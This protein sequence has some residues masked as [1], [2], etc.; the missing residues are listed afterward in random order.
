MIIWPALLKF[1]GDDELLFV[2]NQQAWDS[3]ASVYAASSQPED[4]L[5]DSQGAKFE[6]KKNSANTLEPVA[7]QQFIELDSLLA[8]IKLHQSQSGACC[9]AKLY[10]PTIAEAVLSLKDSQ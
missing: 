7:S 1:T 9:A 4:I 5:V 8:L 2:A 10:F 6:L 3:E